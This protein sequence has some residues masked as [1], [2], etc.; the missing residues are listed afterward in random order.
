MPK[1]HRCSERLIGLHLDFIQ[2]LLLIL[3]KT[4]FLGFKR[5]DLHPVVH[6]IPL[7]IFHSF[8]VPFTLFIENKVFVLF[9]TLQHWVILLLIA[10]C[11]L[12]FKFF[13]SQPLLLLSFQLP[14]QFNLFFEQFL[15]MSVSS[16]QHLFSF[17]RYCVC[18]LL[19][20]LRFEGQPSNP[21]F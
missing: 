18:Y 2:L 6:Q 11:L 3:L 5:L 10:L 4:R 9:V 12:F 15:L 14:F 21:V 16:L 20:S 19:G 13:V 17:Q 8:I 7:H 1:L